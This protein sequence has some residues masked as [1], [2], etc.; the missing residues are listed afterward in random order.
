MQ[1][2]ENWHQQLKNQN[3]DELIEAGKHLF[4]KHGLLQ[5]K[6]KDIC[7]E[8]NLSRV[9]YYKHF[10]SIDEL[11]L[12]IQMQLVET[13]T[14]HVGQ[15]ASPSGSG[16]E[17]LAAMLNAWVSFAKENPDHI[18]FIQLF[19]INYELVHFQ[20][21][22]K[23]TYER[24]IQNGK[25]NHFLLEALNSGVADGSIRNA[26]PPLK[27]AQFIFTVMMGMLQKM[28]THRSHELHQ[29]DDQMTKQLVDML[30]HYAGNE[31]NR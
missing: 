30:L 7:A 20:P 14:Q 24:F 13:M 3:R 17:Q 11:L 19:D 1:A 15:A 10:Q 21:E 12:T 22:L 6:I 5:V 27:L 23:D 16:L 8:A 9:T 29:L 25:E 2:N 28:F 31:D 26:T 4:L 18:R